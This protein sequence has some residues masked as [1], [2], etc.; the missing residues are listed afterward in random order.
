VRLL[1]LP[2]IL[3]KPGMLCSATQLTGLRSEEL[4]TSTNQKQQL[5]KNM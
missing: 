5:N 4:C 1:A 2:R 3:T